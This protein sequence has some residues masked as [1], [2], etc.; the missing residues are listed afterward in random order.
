MLLTFRLAEFV[1]CR[2]STVRGVGSPP[3]NLHV[4]VFPGC[5]AVHN[6]R[7]RAFY[8]WKSMCTTSLAISSIYSAHM[9]RFALACTAVAFKNDRPKNHP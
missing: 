2:K 3:C 1:N 4:T 6:L 8:I 9:G 5:D 7:S